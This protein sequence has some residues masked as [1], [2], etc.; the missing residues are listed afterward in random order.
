MAWIESHQDLRS[1]PKTRRAARR[2]GVSTAALSGHL[3]FLWHWALDHADD[4][5]VSAF[6]PDDIADAAGWDGDPD[7]FFQALT[8]C[9]PGEKAGFLEPDGLIGD[10]NDGKRSPLALHDWW[11]Y[12]GKLVA[13]RRKD[14]ERKAKARS[15][16]APVEAPSD[17]TPEESPPDVP[18]TSDGRR[19]DGAR[20]ARVP[21]TTQ[22][23][24]TNPA[25]EGA[26]APKFAKR[27]ADEVREAGLELGDHDSLHG[28][29]RELLAHGL[30]IRPDDAHPVAM[31][32]T[33]D[34]YRDATGE[35]IPTDTRSMLGRLYRNYAPLRV[36]D[37][38][39]EA[40]SW[41]AGIGE[42]Y[43]EDAKSIGKYVTSIL[44][45]GAA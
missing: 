35:P 15:S 36:F 30:D 38:I 16:P 22:P 29:Y 17:A 28:R 27:L 34:F 31:G 12:A 4:G 24:P 26:D 33:A 9:G 8:D 37:A 25:P 18:R 19:T 3:H 2:L 21:N 45:K 39:G 10:P 40:V 5:D 1:N 14:A 42:T 20:T 32:L 23:N 13:K 43:A 41:G 44:T 6:D 11:E 7:E